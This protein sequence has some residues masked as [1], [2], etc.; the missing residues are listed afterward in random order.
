MNE[1][2]WKYTIEAQDAIKV[3]MPVGSKVLSVQMQSGVPCIWVR[4]DPRR[5]KE[6]RY[7]V[8]RGTGHD[9]DGT[10]GKFVGTF[11]MAHLGLVF[12]L[13]EHA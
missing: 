5:I 8:V 11:Q 1:Q 4:V 13:F 10:E 9:F 3:D 6:P 12:H 7:F 2:I